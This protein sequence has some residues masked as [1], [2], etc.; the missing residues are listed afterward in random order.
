MSRDIS[1][2]LIRELKDGRPR[3]LER[4]QAYIRQ[5]SLSATGEGVE[6][7][8]QLVAADLGSLGAEVEV[9]QGVDYPVVYA[10]IDSG[11]ERTVLIHGMYDTV[12]ADASEWESDPFTAD[13]VER[14]GVQCVMGRGAED[15]KGPL[16][17]VVSVVEAHRQ[18]HVE[19]PVN[20]ILLFEAS[21]LGSKSLPAFV[22]ERKAELA[23]A[24][25]AY[26]P[27][28]T[29]R[30]DGTA[31]AWLGVKGLMTL[32]VRVRGGQWGAPVGSEA[33]GLHSIWVANPIHRLAAALASLKAP[34]DLSIVVE[35]FFDG[36]TPPDADQLELVARL[37]ERVNPDLALGEAHARRFKQADFRAALEAY[38]LG[39]EINVSG[40]SGGTV[41]EDGHKVELP[42]E[43][44]ASMDIRPLDGM[45]VDG[46]VN[47][48]R[49]HFD[50]HGF[51]EVE[52]ELLNG[53][54]GA[55]MSAENWAVK[56]LLDTYAALGHDPEIW[57][58]TST[59][60]S[61]S[62]FVK[63][64]GVPW[65]ATTLGHA[66]NKHAPNEYVTLEGYHDSIGFISHLMWTLGSASAE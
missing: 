19:L 4:L 23:D 51:E 10:R 61:N 11:A 12:P 53:Y 30:P 6:A 48:L 37:A 56:A 28:H 63:T 57:P 17:S 16:A 3:H 14:N 65:I 34:D 8:A 44:V 52:I 15:T 42:S 38:C 43:A 7:M 27:W 41:I 33:H 59:S 21:E 5:P 46:V 36:V 50:S 55:S 18:A 1:P 39:T 54:E 20:L 32:K 9:A 47:A 25:V 22:V 64:L 40:I 31:V 13:L 45:T 60:I 24:D 29:Q 49:R 66:G 2:G 35:G 26:W 58:R 62:S